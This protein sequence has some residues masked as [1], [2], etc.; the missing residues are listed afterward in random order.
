MT[1]VLNGMNRMRQALFEKETYVLALGSNMGGWDVK[2]FSVC[3]KIARI[4]RE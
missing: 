4:M 2:H 1:L 3:R